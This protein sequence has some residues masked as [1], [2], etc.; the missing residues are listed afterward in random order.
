MA[1][2]Q[3]DGARGTAVHLLTHYLRLA[4]QTPDNSKPGVPFKWDSDNDS[5]VAEIVDAI[6]NAAREEASN[7]LRGETTGA[8]G[9]QVTPT[10]YVREAEAHLYKDGADGATQEN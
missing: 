4:T 6:L 8:D 9:V 1:T 3:Y 7:V 2:N 10:V 5:E